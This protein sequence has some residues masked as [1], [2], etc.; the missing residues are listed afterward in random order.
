MQVIRCVCAFR[1]S[2]VGDNTITFRNW[3]AFA[4]SKSNFSMLHFSRHKISDIQ[5]PPIADHTF[6]CSNNYGSQYSLP[7]KVSVSGSDIKKKKNNECN[8][9]H[10]VHFSIYSLC[11]TTEKFTDTW[12][13]I[14]KKNIHEGAGT[15]SS[16]KHI[17]FYK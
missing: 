9:A 14:V 8:I 11:M 2:C 5:F 15:F 3:E 1:I 13:A 12:G 7:G 6:T 16:G 17:Y 10:Y 4:L